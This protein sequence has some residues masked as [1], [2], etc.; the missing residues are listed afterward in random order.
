MPENKEIMLYRIVQEMVNNTLK[1]AEAKKIEMTISKSTD[2]LDINYTDDG[3]GFELT[4]K[5]NS[6][7]LGL[8]SIRS[9]VNFLN[10]KMELITRPGHGV[11]YIIQKYQCS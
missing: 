1:H 3:M 8:Q 5:V 9:R 6:E 11:S 2:R 4:E 7:S 10:G